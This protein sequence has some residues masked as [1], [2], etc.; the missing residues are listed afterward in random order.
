MVEAALGSK[1]HEDALYYLKKTADIRYRLS[2][3]KQI[4]ED[5]RTWVRKIMA[6]RMSGA[7]LAESAPSR[8]V[9]VRVDLPVLPP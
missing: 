6:D 3:R 2:R 8:S 4:V 1:D 9:R 7:E 5:A